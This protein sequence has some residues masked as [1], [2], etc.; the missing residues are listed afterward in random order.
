MDEKNFLVYVSGVVGN[1][2]TK[3]L[4]KE[5]RYEL[6]SHFSESYLDKVLI[7]CDN[8]FEY[9]GGIE[10]SF[11]IA[12]GGILTALWKMCEENGFGLEYNLCD[13][14]ILQGTIEISN[15][16]DLNPYR[17][18]TNNAKIILVRNE[19]TDIDDENFYMN[20]IGKTND[21]KKRVRIDCDSESYLT[22][23]YKDEIDKVIPNYIKKN[24]Y[25]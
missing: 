16:F 18:L 23:D 19:L 20:F 2:G 14:P 8:E 22:R 10:S 21:S 25:G 3:I 17:L 13:I 4:I 7:D 15:F 24:N 1:L 5:K 9:K 12:K 6:L 11:I